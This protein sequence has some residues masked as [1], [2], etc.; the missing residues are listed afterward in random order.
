LEPE[1][2]GGDGS[3]TLQSRLED[4]AGG[5]GGE[6]AAH[7][8]PEPTISDP[9]ALLR[10]LDVSGHFHRDSRVGRV[11]HRG[12]VSL[13]ENVATD[14]LHIVV[15]GN[16]VAAHV[17]GVSPL[18]LRS[19]GQSAYS[20]SRALA[21]NLAGM[22]QDLLRLLRGRQGD[23]RCELNCEWVSIEEKHTA[24]DA[25]LRESEAS[26]CSVQLEAR[27]AG[28]LDEARLRTALG[29]VLGAGA[30]RAG[31]EVVD[32][33]DDVA[34]AAARER[35]QSMV[36]AATARPPLYVCL[37]RHPGG[38]VLMLNLNHAASDGF[39]A[40]QVMRFIARSYTADAD[41]GLPLDFL[42][43]RDL[44]VRPASP[45]VSAV[46]RFSKRAVERLR[47]LFTRPAQLAAVQ[48]D[49]QPGYGFHQVTLPAEET[50][51]IVEA[52]RSHSNTSILMTALHLTIGDWNAQHGAPGRRVAVLVPANL[53]PAQ[54][55]PDTVGNFSVT[56]RMSTSRRQRADPTAAL[57]AIGRQSARNKRTRTGIALIAALERAG[58]L[59]LW[60]KQSVVVL[61]PLTGNRQVDTAM[62][63]NL[64]PQDEAP[65]FGP[66]VGETVEVWF[67]TPVRSPL[68]LCLGAIAVGGRL[69][70]MFRYPHRLFGRDA[71][72]RFAESYVDHVRL[73]T[74]TYG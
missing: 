63:C 7:A 1:T 65:S 29:V 51:R 35:L 46:V 28:A 42:A 52:E 30:Q 62:L 2:P 73:V 38:D 69:H 47:D 57:K 33:P 68:S 9:V 66:D 15:E 39:G 44:P 17:D 12:M 49:D 34:L 56:V 14:S 70:L 36:V 74:A 10:H 31:L 50:E 37:A 8:A 59:A 60:A 6:A 25:Q 13:R 61:E 53:R 41:H 40:L 26:A 72:R 64:G 71:A 27:V 11:Y 20:A 5:P 45:P 67:S 55:P 4:G 24:E 3:G 19:E 23:H 54:L 18:D 22:V 43:V 21:H 32:C 48:P 58:L 16:R